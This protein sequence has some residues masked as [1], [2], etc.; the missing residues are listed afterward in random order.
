MFPHRK[1]DWFFSELPAYALTFQDEHGTARIA[2][3]TTAATP[4]IVCYLSPVDA[5]IELLHFSQLGR[6]Y[7]IM[8]AQ[9]LSPNVFRDGDGRGLIAHVHLGWPVLHGRLLQRPDDTLARCDWLMHHWACEPLR[10]EFDE[11]VLG[12]ADRLRDW[13]GL[14]AWRETLDRVL[15][16]ESGRLG[17]VV[18]QALAS[19][20]LTKGD[21]S[22]CRQ[23][24][25]FDPE[26]AQWHFVPRPEAPPAIQKF[27]AGEP[28]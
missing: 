14:F 6:Q 4:A 24:A 23:V 27:S 11:T 1:D 19:I 2:T 7:Q 15:E 16:W 3:E 8:P 18:A 28:S 26:T 25:L 10:F 9:M 12:E 5:L 20:E 21:V 13:A 22:Q 17:R